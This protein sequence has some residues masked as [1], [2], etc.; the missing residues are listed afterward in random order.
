MKRILKTTVF[1]LLLV[2]TL[3]I[4]L[5]ACK[6]DKV[7]T[8]STEVYEEVNVAELKTVRLALDKE[9]STNH[10]GLFVSYMQDFFGKEGLKLDFVY[11][12]DKS[13][14]QLLLDGDADFAISSQEDVVSTIVDDASKKLVSLATINQNNALGVIFRKDSGVKE[15]KDLAGKKTI[16][17][18]SLD[19]ALLK[20]VLEENGVDASTI[21]FVKDPYKEEYTN[22]NSGKVDFILDIVPWV[23]PKCLLNDLEIEYIYLGDVDAK[24]NFY[25]PLVVSTSEYVDAN[26]AEVEK[27]LKAV[28]KGYMYTVDNPAI[29]TLSMDGKIENFE[30]E[31]VIESQIAISPYHLDA[32]GKFGHIDGKKW[33]AF[34]A[35]LFDK[36]I[37]KRKLKV[38]EGFTN[39]YLPKK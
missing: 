25:R 17:M 11:S 5:T 36:G 24:Y 18:G 3:A 34:N 2:S 20:A 14:E 4:S 29:S 39:D 13:V 31:I 10:T 12:D 30:R 7:E 23:A 21:S 28:E 8:I 15:L 38:G 16:D 1:A 32:D 26:K 19:N 22:L 35:W 6:K 37:I 27:F 9:I 33:D